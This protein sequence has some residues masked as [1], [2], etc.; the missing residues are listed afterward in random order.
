MTPNEMK[1]ASATVSEPFVIKI[2]NLTDEKLYNIPII[3]KLF[4]SSKKVSYENLCVP[5]NDINEVGRGYEM[6]LNQLENYEYK[7][8]IMY[9]QCDSEHPKFVKRQ[10]NQIWTNY[11][12]DNDIIFQKPENI[13][14]DPYQDQNGIVVHRLNFR[15]NSK[16]NLIMSY[17]M[18]DTFVIVRLYPSELFSLN[19]VK[20]LIDSP[21][22]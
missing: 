8:S 5:D 17:L 3:D 9:V 1:E 13:M 7:I 18:P 16:N 4:A 11:I 14:V 20:D 21:E 19:N 12:V 10:L 6:F 2:S 22:K 15:L